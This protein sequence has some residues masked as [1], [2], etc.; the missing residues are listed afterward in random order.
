MPGDIKSPGSIKG[1]EIYKG[2]SDMGDAK[3]T[4]E[5]RESNRLLQKTIEH[6]NSI[7]KGFGTHDF[8]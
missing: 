3:T 5:L 8:S 4:D 6:Q 2:N 1:E 7:I